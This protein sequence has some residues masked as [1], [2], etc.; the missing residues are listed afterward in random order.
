M[1]PS[2]HGGAEFELDELSNGFIYHTRCS[3]HCLALAINERLAACNND[4]TISK[5][6]YLVKRL[7]HPNLLASLTLRYQP[8]VYDT[9]E[10]VNLS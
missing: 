2:D 3:S 10:I 5:A 4:T 1:E 9:P 6:R 7:I 8:G